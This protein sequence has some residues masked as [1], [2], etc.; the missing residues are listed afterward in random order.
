MESAKNDCQN[1]VIQCSSCEIWFHSKCL[2]MSKTSLNSWSVKT[3]SFFCGSCSFGG[4]LYDAE[5]ALQRYYLFIYLFISSP[6]PLGSQGEL[7]V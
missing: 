6:E 1:D 3:L 2:G 4:E 7:I 5:K